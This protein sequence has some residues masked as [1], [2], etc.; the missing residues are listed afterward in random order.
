MKT[1]FTLLLLV[2]L[3]PSG[4]LYAQH[5]TA[6]SLWKKAEAGIDKKEH[7]DSLYNQLCEYGQ[8]FQQ[9]EDWV[10]TGR[11]LY[12]RMKI[13]DLK[14]ED[15]LFFKNARYMDSVLNNSRSPLLLQLVMHLLKAQRIVG[16][17]QQFFFRKDKANIASYDTCFDYAAMSREQLDS[18]ATTHLD[19]ALAH[20]HRFD[21]TVAMSL[22]WLSADPLLFLFRPGPT[23][24]VYGEIIGV[25]TGAAYGYAA[26]KPG[27]IDLSLPAAAMIRLPDSSFRQ[28]PLFI[29]LW[30]RYK[31]WMQEHSNDKE[32]VAYIESL[33][34][35]FMYEYGDKDSA[36][37]TAYEQ[38]LQR[39]LML[40]TG[41][42][43]VH[44]ILQLSYYWNELAS[45]YNSY[46]DYEDYQKYTTDI[47]YDTSKRWLYARQAELYRQHEALLDSFPFVKRQLEK[48]LAKIKVSGIAINLNNCHMPGHS[49][50]V[51]LSYRNASQAYIKV[52]RIDAD[53]YFRPGDT[54]QKEQ[55]LAMPAV[56]ELVQQ[57]PGYGDYQWHNTWLKLDA[58]A[59][60]KYAIIYAD[61][62]I[63][64][65]GSRFNMLGIYVTSIAGHVQNRRLWVLDRATGLP[66]TGAGVTGDEGN[67]TINREGYADVLRDEEDLQVSFRADTIDVDADE[68]K[69]YLPDGVYSKAEYNNLLAF[70]EENTQVYMYTDRGIYRPGQT[71]YYKGILLTRDVHTGAL[72]AFNR[73][74]LRFPLFRKLFNKM[75]RRLADTTL[76][77]AVTDAFNKQVDS[78]K[79]KPGRYGSFSGSFQL[80]AAAA[81]GSWEF[82]TTGKWMIEY[83]YKR[84]K[85]EEYKRPTF[86]VTYEKPQQSLQL[87]DSFAVKL[88]VKSLA[89]APLVH[90]SV[91]WNVLRRCYWQNG[92]NTYAQLNTGKV[93]TNDQ[94]EYVIIVHDSL[95]QHFD[96][97]DTKAYTA[98]YNFE[99]DVTDLTGESSSESFSMTL[100]TRPV[101][102]KVNRMPAIMNRAA[103]PSLQIN[104]EDDYTGAVQQRVTVQLFR[105]TPARRKKAANEIT[106]KGAAD[107]LLYTQQ[108]WQQWFPQSV[109]TADTVKEEKQV[110]WDTVW[111]AGS[112][113]QLVLPEH[114]LEAGNYR[115]EMTAYKQGRIY[116]T[117]SRQFAVFD[118]AANRFPRAENAFHYLQSRLVK[119]RRQ[120]QWLIGHEDDSVYAIY[121]LTWYKEGKDGVTRQCHFVT[122]LESK[123][124][125]EF[126]YQLPAGAMGEVLCTYWYIKNNRICSVEDRLLLPVR[127]TE[128][129][130][131]VEQYRSRLVPGGKETFT[132]SVTT[133]SHNDAAELMTTLYDASLDQLTTHS[134]KMPEEGR[135]FYTRNSWPA[136]LVYEVSGS[137]DNS[138]AGREIIPY[139]RLSVWWQGDD[140]TRQMLM[141]EKENS[142]LREQRRAAGILM[143]DVVVVGYGSVSKMVY[144]GA[145]VKT[146]SRSLVPFADME[147]CLVVVDG[148]IYEKGWKGVNPDSIADA[149]VLKQTDATA[150]YGA[151]AAQGV[152]IISTT[153]PV[154][155]PVKQEP[156]SLT[157]AVVRKQFAETAFFYPHMYA[158]KNGRYTVSFTLPE[159]VTAW[160]WKMLAH[161]RK[162]GFGYAEKT[163]VSQLPLMVQPE[164]PRLLYQGDR[165]VLKSRIT[166]LD[167]A[168]VA[169][170]VRCY[171]EDVVTGEDITSQVISGEAAK[172]FRIAATSHA[173]SAFVLQVP[174]RLLH[175]LKIR[176]TAAAAASGDG[177]EH[178]IPILT[179]KMLVAAQVPIVLKDQSDTLITAPVLP[180]DAEPYGQ[181]VYVTPSLQTAVQQALPFLADYPY[182]CAEQTFN[183]L[184][185][186]AMALSLPV[187][188]SNRY[189]TANNDST[190]MEMPDNLH[191]NLMPWL[192][193][194]NASALRQ[195]RLMHL[196]DT[197][198]NSRHLQEHTATLTGM[199]LPNGGV[200]WFK[201]G[202]SN[203]YISCYLMAGLARMPRESNGGANA[204]NTLHN[205]LL[206][207]IIH[208]C[209]SFFAEGGV[210]NEGELVFYIYART[211]WLKEYPLTAL[212]MK[213]F[214]SRLNTFI[215]NAGDYT[216]GQQAMF[217]VALQRYGA[218][219]KTFTATPAA[220]LANIRS[221]AIS[222]PANGV[223]WKELA[224]A[225][226]LTTSAEETTIQLAEAFEQAGQ[227]SATVKGIIQWLLKAKSD[228]GWS[229]TKATADAVA[230]LGRHKQLTGTPATLQMKVDNRLLLATDHVTHGTP[231]AFDT[232]RGGFSTG[233]MVNASG[234]ST[235]TGGVQFY[236]FTAQPPESTAL[237]AVVLSRKLEKY[238]N[239]TQ[240][241]HPVLPEAVLHIGDKIRV[242][243]TINTPRFLQYVML[244]DKRAAALEPADA[245]SGYTYSDGISYYKSVRDAGMHFF[246]ERISAG[247]ST[248]S[249][250]TVVR[251]EGH[252]TYAPAILQC[253]YAPAIKAYTGTW[254]LQVNE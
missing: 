197:I 54:R 80:P 133:S 226:D 248:I 37:N 168:Q 48:M 242:S 196:M 220:L 122:R 101:T 14:T 213:A 108:Q 38:Y 73:E 100:S 137:L 194:G 131:N 253:M 147:K 69:N 121:Q 171:I 174:Q 166:N 26:R 90:A 27:T 117:G 85:V 58:L 170:Q 180:A 193:L 164:M 62:A 20:S 21:K 243:L 240:Q 169:G 46:N 118:K 31:A 64:K 116:G 22:L 19:A 190:G 138:Q 162:G 173:A 81:T 163:L 199:Q 87:G 50:P 200:S 153:G 106:G 68:V 219:Y 34:R 148:V 40:N 129:A 159:S 141:A 70:Y 127:K 30:H 151:R 198:E 236:Y 42:A 227:D 185:A 5:L 150:L 74:N 223:R 119:G 241:W 104:A 49:I 24:I 252:F 99:A 187:A 53:D 84:F 184:L 123:G 91:T 161:T 126:V 132:V 59:A 215:N 178:I 229:T 231:Y 181:A 157:T 92:V 105:D 2:C 111:Q 43:R 29:T 146:T 208:Y 36:S 17:R 202:E 7:L 221:R 72:L 143:H 79:V 51:M 204:F 28:N 152:I 77:I 98:T 6:D 107:V 75:V 23:D 86:S 35:R 206:P 144:T 103:L 182:N 71:V 113:Q 158:D 195:R 8:R 93:Y 246:A 109:A 244:E 250:E 32:A 192:K 156:A 135:G 65:S 67:Y 172:A 52:V 233:G 218:Y 128:V 110:L 177:E 175:P 191:S 232:C 209:D 56:Y 66:L 57:L 136:A 83:N 130:V 186:H 238:E 88:K 89:G 12:Y 94:G 155:L 102:I 13:T 245:G 41:A 134:W 237:T 61:T 15:S 225:D 95:M 179:P 63:T 154:V 112:R 76:T 228:H 11:S 16:Y 115:L 188:D 235:V 230:L 251:Y 45:L 33:A 124:L 47:Q 55:L 205:K 120:V 183:K 254:Q 145:S 176:I 4:A 39:Q 96:F 44:S 3:W 9:S 224:D 149:V 201:G 78:I 214:D 142:L 211:C 18:L 25:T 139:K 247:Y 114:V 10:A 97:P 249:Y 216:L 165:V 60:G 207:G 239:A 234:A 125:H 212:Q 82:T 160:K 203:A 140:Y 210:V 1:L 167:S 222:D 217:I 189:K